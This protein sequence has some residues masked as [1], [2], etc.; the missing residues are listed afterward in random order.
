MADEL[1]S[2]TILLMLSKLD[3]DPWILTVDVHIYT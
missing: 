2:G 3:Y 1:V